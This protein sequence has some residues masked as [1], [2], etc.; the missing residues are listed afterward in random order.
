MLRI[1]RQWIT[2]TLG[3]SKSEANGTLVLIML[4][5][6]VAVFPKIYLY[7]TF[8]PA[9]G[10]NRDKENLEKWANELNASLVKKEKQKKVSVV[11]DVRIRSFSFDPN[12]V[13]LE[14]LGELGFDKFAARNL[15]NYREK[16]GIFKIKADLKRIYGISEDRVDALWDQIQLPEVDLAVAREKMVT[17]EEENTKLTIDLNTANETELQKI[18][19]IGPKLSARIVKFRERLGGFHG[20]QQLEEVYGLDHDVRTRLQEVA[21]LTGGVE[22]IQLN[23][24][25]VSRFYKHPYIDYNIAHAIVNYRAQHGSFDSL[26]QLRM[27]KIISDSLYQ[28]IYPYLS[29]DQ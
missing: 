25:S 4:I 1:I 21:V 20:L 26:D 11:N 23:V 16:G 27:I 18:R 5:L 10:F 9:V 14:Q 22:K 6:I 12:T 17:P 15:V 2:D 29:L 28:K 7:N 3:F 8:T 19:G 24:D 13:T